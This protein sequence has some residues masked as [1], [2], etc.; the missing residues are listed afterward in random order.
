MSECLD[1]TP[2]M[3]NKHAIMLTALQVTR[4]SCLQS[5]SSNEMLSDKRLQP[6]I[7]RRLFEHPDCFVED[8]TDLKIYSKLYT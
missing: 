8:R 1:N 7:V 6:H 3:E 2:V 4:Q 5:L